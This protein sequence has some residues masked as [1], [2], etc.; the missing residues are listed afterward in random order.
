MIPRELLLDPKM[1]AIEKDLE[2]G[3]QKALKILDSHPC[4]V[5]KEK[6]KEIDDYLAFVKKRDVGENDTPPKRG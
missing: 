2:K 6:Q 3:K 4:P 1:H 5:S